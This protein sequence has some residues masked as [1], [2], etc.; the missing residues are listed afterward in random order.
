MRYFFLS[1]FLL[2]LGGFF[3]TYLNISDVE[4]KNNPKIVKN[5]VKLP[6]EK[7][8]IKLLADAKIEYQFPAKELYLKVNLNFIPKTKILYQTI[9]N[10]LNKYQIFG[11]EQILSL[12]NIKYSIIKSKNDLKLFINFDKKREAI[13]IQKL[14][15]SY[16]FKVKLKKVEIKG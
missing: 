12:N 11:I 14:F 1:I 16:D 5:V 7:T 15:D 6:E 9:I 8:I 13:K 3:I 2:I 4:I 10:N